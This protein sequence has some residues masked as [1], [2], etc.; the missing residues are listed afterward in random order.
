M[1]EIVLPPGTLV[2]YVL[3]DGSHHY[4]STHCRC[5]GDHDA[6]KA[7]TIN[8][9]PRKPAQAKCCGAPCRCEC[10]EEDR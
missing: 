8:G 1:D 9:G 3:P 4:Y 6:C 10:H 2:D 7:T 5:S